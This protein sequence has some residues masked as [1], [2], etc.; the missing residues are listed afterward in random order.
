VQQLFRVRALS[1][2]RNTVDSG[3]LP[4]ADGPYRRSAREEPRCVNALARTQES[5]TNV[6]TE[7]PA[8]CPGGEAAVELDLERRAGVR[9]LERM[10]RPGRVTSERHE[11]TEDRKPREVPPSHTAPAYLPAEHVSSRIT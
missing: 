5:R 3:S 10:S 8:S 2:T 7:S 1:R 9:D 6:R 11:C 4:G